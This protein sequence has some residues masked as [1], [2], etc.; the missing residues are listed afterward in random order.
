MRFG[1]NLLAG[2]DWPKIRRRALLLEELGFDEVW[3]PDHY[4][5]MPGRP[6]FGGW[7]LL[8]AIAGATS[9]IRVGTLV[10]SIALRAPQMLALDAITV[11]HISGGRLELGVGAGAPRDNPQL[12]I[13]E[14]TAG[15]RQSRLAE[16][17]ELLDHLLREPMTEFKGIHY[18]ATGAEMYRRPVQQP[19]PPLV[20]GAE[21]ERSLRLAARF[22]DGWSVLAGQPQSQAVPTLPF[23]LAVAEAAKKSRRLDEL[24]AAAGRDPREIR[25]IVVGIRLGFDALGSARDY[26]RFVEA[27]AVAG[28]D[29][30]VVGWHR[31]DDRETEGT[32]REIATVVIPKL[33]T[34]ISP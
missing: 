6:W 11:D 32:L 28:F 34:S 16:Y 4:I 17:V 13:G 27:Y 2:A 18:L 10:S 33:R 9:R 20:L 1:I 30:F 19:R 29:S 3:L 14:W 24:C 12:G 15:D 26:T 21:S 23:E 25:R 31:D 8:A 7:P 5:G 22:A